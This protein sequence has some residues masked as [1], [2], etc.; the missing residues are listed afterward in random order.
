MH[1]MNEQTYKVTS[2]DTPFQF[3]IDADT[4]EFGKHTHGGM[5]K[6]V[7]LKYE[8]YHPFSM[9]LNHLMSN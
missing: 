1:E 8:N 9:L 5:F 3:S 7:G 4:S 6:K 2:C